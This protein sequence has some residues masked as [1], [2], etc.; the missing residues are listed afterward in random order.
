MRFILTLRPSS[1]SSLIIRQ[2]TLFAISMEDDPAIRT[3]TELDFD[4]NYGLLAPQQTVVVR[5]YTDDSDDQVLAEIQ[6]RFVV[7]FEPSE[8]FIRRIEV[9]PRSIYQYSVLTRDRCIEA[10]TQVLGLGSIIWFT[11]TARKN[12]NFLLV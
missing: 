5:A 12:I 8:E 1:Y 7:M 6:P 11:P 4:I 9:S 3:L 2:D 10:P